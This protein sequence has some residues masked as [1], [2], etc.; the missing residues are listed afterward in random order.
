MTLLN[1]PSAPNL[2]GV[3]VD[4]D[5]TLIDSNDAH[6]QAWVEALARGGIHVSFARVRRLIGMGSD[7]LLPQLTGI[8]LQSARGQ[9]LRQWRK[10]IFISRYLPILRPFPGARALLQRMRDD[11]LQLV[12]ASSAEAEELDALLRTAGVSDLIATTTSSSD[13][14]HSKPN[15][16]ILQAALARASLASANVLMLGD[17]PYDIAA[18]QTAGIDT[19]VFRCGGWTDAQLTGAIAIY[20]DPADLLA[21]YAT[22]PFVQRRVRGKAETIAP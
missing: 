18:A 22:S 10:E 5:G 16:D 6:A 12:V 15:P 1:P 17:T 14:D 20:E 2:Q 13:A 8:D 11:G 21:H 4:V 19:V 9:E 3:L 7:H